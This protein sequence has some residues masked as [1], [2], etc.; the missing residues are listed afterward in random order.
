[1]K[2]KAL[3]EKINNLQTSL[4]NTKTDLAYLHKVKK[5]LTNDKDVMEKEIETLR[6]KVH[7]REE[8]VEDNLRLVA[9]IKEQLRKKDLEF[10]AFQA[11][12]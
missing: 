1:M 7:Q 2:I 3:N 8:S 5:G 12:L 4:E 10:A 9:E 6:R 11:E